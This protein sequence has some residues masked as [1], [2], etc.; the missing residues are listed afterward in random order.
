[1][2]QLILFDCLEEMGKNKPVNE[3]NELMSGEI[4]MVVG[5]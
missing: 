5:V 4:K 2:N 3:Q 1:M